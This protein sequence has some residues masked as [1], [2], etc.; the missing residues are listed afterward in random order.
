MHTRTLALALSMA[1]LGLLL[2][3]AAAA[4]CQVPCGIY[5]DDLRFAAMEEDFTTIEKA[6]TQIVELSKAGD[7]NYNQIVRW[8]V[9]KEEHAEKIV[10]VLTD[11]FL[12]Q[13]IAV[14]G[15]GDAAAAERY[16][17]MLRQ[18]HELLVQTMKCTQTTDLAH[19]EA[20][21]KLLHDFQHTYTGQP[22]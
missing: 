3:A 6:M 4:H 17:R 2:P 8:V 19:V 13:R 1:T 14:P 5:G 10:D 16:T 18:V 20:G 11:Y 15:D 9:T 22:K 12:M 7:R 21:R